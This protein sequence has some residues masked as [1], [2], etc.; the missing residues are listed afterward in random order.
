[1]VKLTNLE[2]A[3]LTKL[4]V[5]SLGVIPVIRERDTYLGDAFKD[6]IPNALNTAPDIP[7]TAYRP[8]TAPS[9]E[10]PVGTPINVIKTPD[11]V[12]IPGD[13]PDEPD[14]AGT[15]L[16][17]GSIGIV[18]AVIIALGLVYSYLRGR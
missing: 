4:E 1:M 5:A 18:I 10:V 11:E 7:V 2:M 13:N 8:P 6:P 17:S 15:G 12:S 14:K 9:Y 16:V 3:N